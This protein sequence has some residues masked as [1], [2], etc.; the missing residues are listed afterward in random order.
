MQ[1]YDMQLDVGVFFSEFKPSGFVAKYFA[2]K[3]SQMSSI[4]L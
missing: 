1:F 2:L 3:V 4:K